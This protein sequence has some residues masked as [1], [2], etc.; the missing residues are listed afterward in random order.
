MSDSDDGEPP[1]SNVHS[2]TPSYLG[3]PDMEMNLIGWGMFVLLLVI[4]VPL[5]PFIAL[6]WVLSKLTRPGGRGST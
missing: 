6:L 4:L 2:A 5:A 1:A 3:R